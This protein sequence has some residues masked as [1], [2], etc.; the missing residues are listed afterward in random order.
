[1][2]L[3]LSL[4]HVIKWLVAVR[5]VNVS[6]PSLTARI[7]ATAGMPTRGKLALWRSGST[8]SQL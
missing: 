4:D 8:R 5:T 6:F 3:E 7:C 2:M 1:M